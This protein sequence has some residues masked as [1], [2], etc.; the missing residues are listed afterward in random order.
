MFG[1]ELERFPVGQLREGPAMAEQ[2][3]KLNV[4]NPA[5]YLYPKANACE[6]G[7]HFTIEQAK[8]ARLFLQYRPI[9][10][11][12]PLIQRVADGVTILSLIALGL[13]LPICVFGAWRHSFGKSRRVH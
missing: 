12:R 6:P 13:M 8:E 2:N 11:K 7:E 1:Y 5:C 10:F 3:G 9:K 4:K